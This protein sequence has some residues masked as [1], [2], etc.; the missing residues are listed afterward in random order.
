M[1]H[2]NPA[3]PN[4]SPA[5]AHGSP[6]VASA[7]RVRPQPSLLLR[8]WWWL[9]HGLAVLSIAASSVG[10]FWQCLGVA[11]ALGHARWR[12][13][14]RVPELAVDRAG[15]WSVPSLR[16]HE[17]RLAPGSRC[18]GWWIRLV[19]VDPEGSLEWIL[20]YDQLDP[21]CW[22]ELTREVGGRLMQYSG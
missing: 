17:L 12:S 4:S 2:P 18:G 3:S 6:P 14:P 9:L 20:L 19:L 22:R 10:L 5:S 13:A 21:R 1:K 15:N 7:L 16:R 11:A 8:A